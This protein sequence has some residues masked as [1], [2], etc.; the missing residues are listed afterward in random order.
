MRHS[1]TAIHLCGRIERIPGGTRQNDGLGTGLR[2]AYGR[3]ICVYT[4][5]WCSVVTSRTRQPPTARVPSPSP[6]WQLQW[7]RHLMSS[8]PSRNFERARVNSSRVLTRTCSLHFVGPDLS[9]MACARGRGP[10][11]ASADFSTT[12]SQGPSAA[13][14]ISAGTSASARG[15]WC[16]QWHSGTLRSIA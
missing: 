11:G 13:G 2:G 5:A 15:H 6:H 16:Q 7:Q 10:R 3:D 1:T 8:V 12:C 4:M 9:C 14:D